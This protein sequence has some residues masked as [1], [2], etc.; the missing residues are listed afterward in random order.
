MP[1]GNV[2]ARRAHLKLAGGNRSLH[3]ALPT[4]C[5]RRRL[6]RR[7]HPPLLLKYKNAT[8]KSSRQA[9]TYTAKKATQY[10]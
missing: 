6:E 1:Q 7:E 8:H 9:L 3:Y 2:A 4:S 5:L 10:S